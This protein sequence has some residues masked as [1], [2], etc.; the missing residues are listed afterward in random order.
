M[1]DFKAKLPESQNSKKEGIS[2]VLS[3]PDAYSNH[4]TNVI[5]SF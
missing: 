3:W 5:F 4:G 2:P 1:R